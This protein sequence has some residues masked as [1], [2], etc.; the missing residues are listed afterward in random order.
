MAIETRVDSCKT[1]DL[2]VARDAGAAPL[3]DAII[4]TPFW[5]VVHSYNNIA[6]QVRRYLEAALPR[7]LA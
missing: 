3:W 7:R 4:R 2:I 6:A 5:D 1:C